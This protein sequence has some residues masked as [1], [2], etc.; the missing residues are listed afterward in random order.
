M[1]QA[2]VIHSHRSVMPDQYTT[3]LL[4]LSIHSVT[5]TR[6]KKYSRCIYTTFYTDLN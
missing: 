5:E 6:Q 3:M 4:Q 2:F 1:M